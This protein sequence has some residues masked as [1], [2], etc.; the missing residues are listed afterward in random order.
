MP[1]ATVRDGVPQ[2]AGWFVVSARDVPWTD[3]GLRTAGRFGGQGEAYFDELGVALCA[4]VER[5]TASPAEA[6]A[7]FGEPRRVPARDLG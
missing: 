4:A 2:T 7:G 1:E 6:Y 5:A 3:D